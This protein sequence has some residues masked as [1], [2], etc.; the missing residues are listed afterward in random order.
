MA[1]VDLFEFS[2]LLFCAEKNG[3]G[4]NEAHKILVDDEVPPM[5]ERKKVS[6]TTGE[7]NNNDYGFSEDSL[8]ILK[9]FFKQ[10]NLEEFTIV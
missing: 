6:Y 10:E 1:N 5:Y 3:Y 4:W 7:I 8:K 9:A 2:D